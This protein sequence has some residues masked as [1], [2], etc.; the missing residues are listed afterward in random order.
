MLCNPTR[1]HRRH[2]P[3]LA[4]TGDAVFVHAAPPSAG[5][6]AGSVRDFVAGWAAGATRSLARY[7]MPL[8]MVRITPPADD[9]DKDGE[10]EG[11]GGGIDG[12]RCET[13]AVTCAC[14]VK[15]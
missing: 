2:K 12:G 15:S 3:Q 11:E 9:K 5:V 14:R 13:T 10:G 6:A 4:F 7:V 1:A 8:R